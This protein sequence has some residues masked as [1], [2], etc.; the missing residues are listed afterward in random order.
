MSQII[1]FVDTPERVL[2][3]GVGL[4]E[5]GKSEPQ[6]SLE[7]LSRLANTAGAEV[8]D[9][10]IQYRDRPDAAYFIGKGKAEE[11]ALL[12]GASNISSVIFDMDLSPAQTR[13][14]EEVIGGKVIDRSRL[15]LDIFAQH[16]RTKEAMLEVELAQLAYQLP[17][18]TRLWTHLSRQVSGT[19]TRTGG[20]G[21]RG[22]GETQLELDRR[23]IRGRI[24]YLKQAMDKIRQNRDLERKSR[25]GLLNV[26]L[27]GYTNAGKSTLLNTLTNEKL[28]TDDKLFSTLDPTTRAVHLTD[29]YNVL[30]T[31]TVG[32][33]KRLPHHLIASFRATLEEVKYSDLLLHVVDASQSNVYEQIVAVEEVLSELEALD[34]P[35]IT[36]FNKMDKLD[37]RSDLNILK[38]K[39]PNN[40]ELSAISGQGLDNLRAMLLK[41]AAKDEIEISVNIPQNE[42]KMLNYIY[43]H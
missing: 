17:R 19:G 39:Y 9:K 26:S 11:I 10:I 37:D 42:G 36:V 6:E 38:N 20:I 23:L 41:I 8:I 34:K 13:N 35:T 32:F 1:E 33:I 16:A 4:P 43:T 5:M 25:K 30:M 27:V 12:W 7:E 28:Y 40:V 24:L 14:L 15:I 2:L 29:K 31:D 21:T 18:L 22:P 3:V